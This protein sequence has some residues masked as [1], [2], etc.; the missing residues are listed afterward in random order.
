MIELPCIIYPKRELLLGA[1]KGS[2]AAYRISRLPHISSTKLYAKLQD[3]N[4]DDWTESS[5]G[6]DVEE[7]SMDD[8]NMDRMDLDGFTNYL[9]P[10]AIALLGSLAVTAAFFKFVLMDY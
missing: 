2:S 6:D 4:E 5:G 3:D 8:Q 9:A 10:Y 7:K 1:K